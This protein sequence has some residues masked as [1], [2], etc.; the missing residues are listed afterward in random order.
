MKNFNPLIFLKSLGA[1]G[2]AI[3]FF[4]YLMFM[5]K[6]KAPI[7]TFDTLKVY[8]VEHNTLYIALILFAII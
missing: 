5:T 7:P 2:L 8:F 1:G 4:M 3:S 6:H